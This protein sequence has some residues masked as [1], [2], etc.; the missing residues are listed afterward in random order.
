VER[1]I[2]QELKVGLFVLGFLLAIGAA[3]F[4]LSGGAQ[5]FARE[6]QLHT[7]FKDVKGLKA[8][9]VVRLAGI[10]VGQVSAVAF[11][12]DPAKKEIDVELT[13][14]TE[15]QERIR[16][17]SLATISSIGLLGDMY[18]TVTVGSPDAP[19]LID[20]AAIASAESVDFLAYADKATSIVENAA[21][22]SRKVDL[23][24]GSDEAASKAGVADS[25][26]HVEAL[27]AEARNGKGILHT[28]LYEESS[29]R[30]VHSILDNVDGIVADVKG[31]TGEIRHG[32][33]IAHA[34]IYGEEGDKLAAKLGDAADA[35]GGLVGDLKSG[36]SLA[37]ALLYDPDKAALVDDLQATMANING[38]TTAVNEGQGT[39]GLLVRD[40]QL[41]EDMRVLM[42]GAQRNVLLRAYIR[43]TVAHGREETGAAWSAP[44]EPK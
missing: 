16:N 31:I 4:V 44:G 13:I 29:G 27:L 28:L 25:L 38:V 9:A 21:S 41:Y 36:D 40:P 22:I 11:S 14:R 20:E 43:S 35:L 10:D 7:T 17:D 23:M 42:G 8:G 34:V 37:H 26:A 12:T 2:L 32:H 5:A 1:N 6:Y 39:L 18:V 33:G 24:L 3:V 15:F 30:K 19:V